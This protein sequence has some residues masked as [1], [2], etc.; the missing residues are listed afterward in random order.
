MKYPDLA[1]ELLLML[2]DDQHEY[3]NMSQVMDSMPTSQKREEYRLNLASNSHKRA[4]RMLEILDVIGV[5][6]FENIGR[7]AAEA[8]SI[9]ALHSYLSE[10]EYVLAIY[11]KRYAA[12]P[13]SFYKEAIPPLTDR[14]MIA[15]QRKQ[16]FGTNWSVTKGGKWF[17]IPVDDFA[18]ANN[19]RAKYG[20]PLMRKPRNLA[21]GVNEWPLGKGPAEPSDQ[22]ALSDEEYAEYTKHMFS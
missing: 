10:M 15:E 17:L 21:V 7:E 16:K 12:D 1:K 6:T 3:R 18:N 8:V 5:P 2:Q 14:I 4:K 9:F 11:Q 19:L 22:K 13:D 20:L